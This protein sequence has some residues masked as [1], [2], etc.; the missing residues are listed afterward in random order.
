MNRTVIIRPAG[1]HHDRSAGS[2]RSDVSYWKALRSSH[3]SRAACGRASFRGRLKPGIYAAQAAAAA[4]SAS[5]ALTSTITTWESGSG[6]SRTTIDGLVVTVHPAGTIWSP[7][8]THVVFRSD[9]RGNSD[10]YIQNSSGT[11][12]ELLLVAPT[13]ISVPTDWSSDGRFIVYH[14]VGEKT[15]YDLWVLDMGE[16][17]RRGRFSIRHSTRLKDISRRTADGWHI[18]PTSRG[19][20][21]GYDRFQQAM[22][23]GCYRGA[24]DRNRHGAATA[25]SS[26]IL[27]RTGN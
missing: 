17:E 8:G 14:T 18:R 16:A 23:S 4:A 2:A 10:L 24:A 19:W 26:S 5:V 7:D 20:R 12:P 22:T 1:R 13:I 15:G 25:K 6:G 27:L 21:C 11:E 9:R 3:P